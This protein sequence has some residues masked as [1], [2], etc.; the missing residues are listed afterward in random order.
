VLA[1]ML[2]WT[3]RITRRGSGVMVTG[4]TILKLSPH[5]VSVLARHRKIVLVSG[6]NGKTTTTSLIYY[7]LATKTSVVSNFTGANLFAGLAAALSKD[8]NAPTAALEVDEMVL[9]WAITETQPDLVVLLNLGRDQL[10]RLSEVRVVAQKWRDAMQNLPLGCAVLA[11]ADDPFVVW[12]SRNWSQI[13]WFSSGAMD[14][15]MQRHVQ[16]V[17]QFYIGPMRVGFMLVAVDSK[18]PRLIGFYG[19]EF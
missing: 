10:D 3:S 17:A 16:S 18:N 1:N 5:A 12:A 9:P 7:A 4:R 2:G 19:R 13:I 11:D 8:R 6:T 15:L 14:T